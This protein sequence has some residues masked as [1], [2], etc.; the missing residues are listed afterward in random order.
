[1]CVDYRLVDHGDGAHA[2]VTIEGHTVVGSFADNIASAFSNATRLATAIVSDPLISAVLPPGAG[3]AI[4]IM[5]QIAQAHTNGTLPD[6][7]PQLQ[8]NHPSAYRLARK[9]LQLPG[10]EE[11]TRPRM[12]SHVRRSP[13]DPRLVDHAL[14]QEG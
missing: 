9:L 3:A 2:T 10:G 5:K 8:E 6:V 1:M 7:L 14:D 12:R 13:D 4:A 11:A